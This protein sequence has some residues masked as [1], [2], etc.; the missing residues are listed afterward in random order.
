[1]FFW[2]LAASVLPGAGDPWARSITA[3]TAAVSSSSVANKFMSWAAVA[4][5][6]LQKSK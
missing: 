5:L 3:A 2:I 1:M 6:D 4:F